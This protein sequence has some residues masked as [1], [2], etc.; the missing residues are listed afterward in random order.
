MLVGTLPFFMSLRLPLPV[1]PSWLLLL[2][3]P[4]PALGTPSTF[5]FKTNQRKIPL[6]AQWTT[7]IKL[8]HALGNLL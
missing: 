7:V 6:Q 4:C 3:L 5:V 2:T 8:Q 1:V